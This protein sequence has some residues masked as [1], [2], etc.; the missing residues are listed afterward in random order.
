MPERQVIC[1]KCSQPAKKTHTRFGV[2]HDHCGLTSWAYK[3]L[4]TQ[5]TLAAR[6]AAHAAFDPVWQEKLTSRSNA[7]KRLA[8]ELGMTREECH[9]SLM[10]EEQ[11]KRVPPAVERI[12]ASLA[13]TTEPEAR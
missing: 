7:Y 10:N 9:I 3:P 6:R 4:A 2:R 13:E 8:A 5:E 12:R 1:P 11:A